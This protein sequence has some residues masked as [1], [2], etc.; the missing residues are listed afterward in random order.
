MLQN[1]HEKS[2]KADKS[3]KNRI[4]VKLIKGGL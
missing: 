2:P 1:P 4:R 3:N